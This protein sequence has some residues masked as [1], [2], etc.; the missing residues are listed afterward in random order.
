MK[1]FPDAKRVG[2]PLILFQESW[3]GHIWLPV[4]QT[5]SPAL[6]LVC[7]HTRLV[8][9]RL[10]SHALPM[11]LSW[12]LFMCAYACTHTQQR[13]F[14]LYSSFS[15]YVFPLFYFSSFFSSLSLFFSNL[16]SEST[17]ESFPVHMKTFLSGC[18]AWGKKNLLNICVF[19]PKTWAW[20]EGIKLD[21]VILRS[22]KYANLTFPVALYLK[23]QTHTNTCPLTCKYM[24]T[25]IY[26][27][28]RR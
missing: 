3:Q 1:W 12:S 20:R 27:M 18:K 16:Y 13:H 22:K 6:L 24:C 19:I 21:R 4:Y 25:Y 7:A 10:H 17:N 5:L 28:L 23:S 15:C 26:L 8:L 14:L 9:D 2:P 11:H